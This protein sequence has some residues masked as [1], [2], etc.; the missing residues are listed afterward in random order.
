[1]HNNHHIKNAPGRDILKSRDPYLDN[2]KVILI[3]FVVVGHLIAVIRGSDFSTAVYTW[4]YSFHMPAFVVITGYLSRSYRGTPRQVKAL[5]TGVL[6]PYLV[7]QV[8]VRVEPWLFFGEPLHLNIFTPAWSNW[9]LLALFAWRLLVPVLQ[10][11]RYPVLF[12]VVIAL[13][14]VLAG[15]ISQGLS[16]ARILSY[17]PFFALGLATTPEKLQ[18]FKRWA[19]TAPVRV[20]AGGYVMIVGLGMY[21]GRDW[22]TSDWF[23]MSVLSTID[24][25]LSSTQHVLMRIAVLAFTTSM[26]IAVLILVPQRHL[27]FSSMGAATLTMYLL[28]EATLLVPRHFIMQWDGWSAPTVLILMVAGVGYALL[29]GTRPVH[30]I[31]K[32]L[33]DPVGTF[34]WLRKLVFGPDQSAGESVGRRD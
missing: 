31:T 11:V 1:M 20:I 26:L 34:S 15:G 29:L 23:M 16:G 24:G 2:A 21:V 12:S 27:F 8:I 17:L 19:R 18:A 25:D 14:S 4:I 33:I 32:W 30:F 3:V 6:V 9:F 7:F 22:V 28:Q 5:V 10:V 13:L